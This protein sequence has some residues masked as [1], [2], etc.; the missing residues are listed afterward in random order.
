M[1][2]LRTAG[3]RR[4][5]RPLSKLHRAQQGLAVLEMALIMPLLVFSLLLLADLGLLFYGYVGASNSLR[6]GARCGVIGFDDNSVVERV[7]EASEFVEPVSITL[8]DRSS[9]AI[10]D[11]FTVTGTFEHQWLTPIVGGLDITQYTRSVSMRLEVDA[12]TKTDCNS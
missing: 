5:V 11:E 9:V 12:F 10:G 3:A 7:T 4:I 1:L 6:E 8:S 2:R